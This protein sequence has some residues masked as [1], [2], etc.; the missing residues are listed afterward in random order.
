MK[1]FLESHNNI[2]IIILKAFYKGLSHLLFVAIKKI[3]ILKREFGTKMENNK[4]FKALSLLG[5]PIG[6]LS[7]FSARR[8]TPNTSTALL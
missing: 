1:T 4:V 2:I 6:F 7:G 5:G 3:I 8:L